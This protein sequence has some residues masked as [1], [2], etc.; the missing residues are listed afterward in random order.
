MGVEAVAGTP[1][2]PPI[3]QVGLQQQSSPCCP[4]QGTG[5][6]CFNF[7]DLDPEMEGQ[8]RSHMLPSAFGLRFP[9]AVREPSVS[10]SFNE[11]PDGQEGPWEF[12]DLVVLQ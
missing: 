10:C 6:T 12:G 3:P 7:R 8:R 11:V 4:L 2:L 9:D 1:S 5:D